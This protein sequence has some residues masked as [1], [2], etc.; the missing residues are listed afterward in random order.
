MSEARWSRPNTFYNL[1][2]H[3]AEGHS[4]TDL[5]PAQQPSGKGQG[6]LRRNKFDTQVDVPLPLN[7]QHTK[8]SRHDHNPF[9]TPPHETSNPFDTT[10]AGIERPN[11]LRSHPSRKG[12]NPRT[13]RPLVKSGTSFGKF[14]FE[15]DEDNR[16]SSGRR[17]SGLMRNSFFSGLD[18][19]FGKS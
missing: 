2:T 11:P 9:S 16:K 3:G 10:A 12:Q 6:S 19:G 14:D 4:N 8:G 1:Y 15:I 17:S 13:Q 18:L 5:I 7:T